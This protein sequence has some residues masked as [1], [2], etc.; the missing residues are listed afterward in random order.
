[1]LS[2]LPYKNKS[3]KVWVWVWVTNTAFKHIFESSTAHPSLN[4]ILF[5]PAHA[6]DDCQ[7]NLFVHSCTYMLI[8]AARCLHSIDSK[9]MPSITMLFKHLYVW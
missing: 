2:S 8:S 3:E 7:H 9:L 6:L 1:M 4:H 5:N